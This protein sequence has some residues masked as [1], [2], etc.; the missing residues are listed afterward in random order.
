M[1]SNYLS[2]V[3]GILCACFLVS[4]TTPGGLPATKTY[5]TGTLLGAGVGAGIG[6]IAG[7][8]RGAA[9]GGAAGALVGLAVAHEQAKKRDAAYAQEMAVRQQI[10]K[11][12]SALNR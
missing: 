12:K 2:L 5:G 3:V 11:K 1:Q 10:D 7:G 6:A 8:G 9:I 4:C